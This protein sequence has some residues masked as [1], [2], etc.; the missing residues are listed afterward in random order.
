MSLGRVL[1]E[2]FQADVVDWLKERV[3]VVIVDSWLELER[4]H[5]WDGGGPWPTG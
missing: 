1:M 4:W 5:G 3:E 2:P